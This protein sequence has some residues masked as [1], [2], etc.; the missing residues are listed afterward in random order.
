MGGRRNNQYI[1]C[2]TLVQNG[3][4]RV[5]VK[6]TGDIKDHRISMLNMQVCVLSLDGGH[7]IELTHLYFSFVWEGRSRLEYCLERA[8]RSPSPLPRP[9][10]AGSNVGLAAVVMMESEK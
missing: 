5:L 1:T 10:L 9:P 4:N 8:E 6:G 7:Q 2:Y 3:S